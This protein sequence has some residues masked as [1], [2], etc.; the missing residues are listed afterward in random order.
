MSRLDLF[1]ENPQHK[2]L[3][4][5]TKLADAAAW[6]AKGFTLL[7]AVL[8]FFGI[9][10]GFLDRVLRADTTAAMWVFVMVGLGLLCALFAAAFTATYRLS[11]FWLL[12]AVG[13]LASLTLI[14]VPNVRKTNVPGFTG[15]LTLLVGCFLLAAAVAALVWKISV[16]LTAGVLVLGVAATAFGLYGATKIAVVSRTAPVSPQVT[17]A[18]ESDDAGTSVKVTVSAGQ[19]EGSPLVVV[20]RAMPRT[21][22]TAASAATTSGGADSGTEELVGRAVLVSDSDGQ[23]TGSAVFPLQA[24]RWSTLRV[25]FCQLEREDQPPRGFRSYFGFSEDP[26][27]LDVDALCTSADD[28]AFRERVLLDLSPSPGLQVAAA[29]TSPAADQLQAAVTASSIPEGTVLE[30]RVARQ[31]GAETATFATATLLPDAAG[32]ASTTAAPVAVATGDVV[33]VC[34]RACPA[35]AECDE[36]WVQIA[37][38]AVLAP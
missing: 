29:L 37:T 12:L 30:A 26:P 13:L 34:Y 10:D 8:T 20:V 9:K 28:A 27:E 35:G 32:A 15:G 14:V 38:T 11:G 6:G 24:D 1:V 16:P 23:T 7:A 25:G 36:D 3:L 2:E 22:D 5:S 33:S 4:D 21:M 17:A 18:L 19:R 31:R